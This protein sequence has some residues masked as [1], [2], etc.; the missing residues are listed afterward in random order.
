MFLAACSCPDESLLH[1]DCDPFDTEE[2]GDT[3]APD[4]D[5]AD[6]DGTDTD[7]A[8]TDGT[9]TDGTDTDGDSGFDSDCVG[10]EEV[11]GELDGLRWELPCVETT[12]N[13]AVCTTEGFDPISVALAGVPGTV[14]DVSL[15]FRGV[16]EERT[17]LGGTQDGPWYTGGA[18]PDESD[19]FNVYRLDVSDPPATFHVNAGTS[20]LLACTRIDFTRTVRVAAGA[21]LTLS[22]DTRDDRQ[23]VNRG[24]GGQPI[25]VP[26]VPP[27]PEP[28]DGQFVQMDVVGLAVAEPEI[29]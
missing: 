15:R 14:Y 20:G 3:D 22:A 19:A 18:D 12:D 16:V 8:D 7:G 9:D 10:C 26:G 29:P 5:G 11:A 25:V 1:D 2:A 27:A 17:Y 23:I 24:S 28:F 21:T 4:T 13:P 6:T